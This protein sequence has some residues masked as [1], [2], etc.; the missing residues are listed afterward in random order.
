ME[1]SSSPIPFWSITKNMCKY[2]QFGYKQSK[3]RIILTNFMDL[4][5]YVPLLTSHLTKQDLLFQ[6]YI[7][8]R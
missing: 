2:F 3:M 7:T 4:K 1:R 6:K 8:M 5:E